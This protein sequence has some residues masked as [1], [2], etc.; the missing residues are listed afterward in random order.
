MDNEN[1]EVIE[2]STQ[3][4][5]DMMIVRHNLLTHS[6]E[7]LESFFSD[8]VNGSKIALIALAHYL[9]DKGFLMI[10]C[11]FHTDHLESMGGVRIGYDEYKELIDRGLKNDDI[12]SSDGK[13]N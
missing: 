4:F 8:K 11:Q 12:I 3:D 1:C 5:V 7:E 2:I 6:V 13:E 9:E 10:D